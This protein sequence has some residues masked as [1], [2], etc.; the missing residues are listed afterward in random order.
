[1]LTQPSEL[2]ITV[3]VMMIAADGSMAVIGVVLMYA[4]E[5]NNP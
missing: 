4:V 2:G 3:D 1:L 5:V